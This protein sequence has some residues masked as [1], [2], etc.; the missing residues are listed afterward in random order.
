LPARSNHVNA[1]S[2]EPAP[3]LYT[4]V[5]FSAAVNAPQYVDAWKPTT[6]AITRFSS[7]TRGRAD[8]KLRRHQRSALIQIQ[9]LPSQARDDCESAN[10][11]NW[12][13]LC[14]KLSALAR[15][16]ECTEMGSPLHAAWHAHAT[17]PNFVPTIKP[18]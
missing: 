18:Y 4:T 17:V 1:D 8:I 7:P 2:V 5:P 9:Q 13:G 15:T 12:R 11:K 16:F 14:S 6:S 10:E 3:E